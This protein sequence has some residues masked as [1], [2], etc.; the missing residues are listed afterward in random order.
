M[1]PAIGS[2]HDCLALLIRP[3][4]PIP[5][6]TLTA[7]FSSK[8]V[9]NAAF[10]LKSLPTH[11]VGHIKLIGMNKFASMSSESRF[12]KYKINSFNPTC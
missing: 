2:G 12:M 11:A 3:W 10:S 6:L 7:A 1:F 4:F 9:D 5:R 8:K